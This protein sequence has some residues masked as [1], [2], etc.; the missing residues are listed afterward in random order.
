LESK[1]F[2]NSGS[3]GQITSGWQSDP[4]VWAQHILS[5]IGDAII[6][7]DI[8]GRITYLNAAAERVTGW[9]VQEAVGRPLR[10]VMKVIDAAR[11]ESD[12]YLTE[13]VV[14]QDAV[15]VADLAANRI[16]VRRDGTETVIE[17]SVAAI[18]DQEGRATG[19]VIVLRVLTEEAKAKALK[20]S[21]LAQ[22]D[23]LTDLPNRTLLKDRLSRAFAL[24]TRY[25][26]S[27]AVL[28]VDLDHFKQVND[29]A[30]HAIGDRVLQSTAGRLLA[31]VRSS[32]TVSRYG[33]DEFVILLSE[34]DR[35]RSLIRVAKKILA[36]ITVPHDLLTPHVSNITAS[37]GVSIFPQDGRDGETLIQ[38]AD[39]AMYWV[40]QHGR[41]NIQFFDGRLKLKAARQKCPPT[42]SRTFRRMR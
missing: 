39:A 26:R 1:S 2:N 9:S 23:G 18:Q 17:E 7:T 10:E 4:A 42:N 15:A 36:A 14:D 8:S 34:I 29:S 40:K 33:G 21:H 25:S 32:D 20:M 11:G 3:E 41:N 12:R 37:M 31:C 5:C 24:A 38:N 16:L 6:S 35:S 28:F 22:Y 30:G 27:L 19:A 13:A